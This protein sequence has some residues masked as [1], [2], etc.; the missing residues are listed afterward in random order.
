MGT[1][2]KHTEYVDQPCT[3]CGSK[4][5]IAK[6]WKEK[7]PNYSGGFTEVACT[8]IECSNKECQ[9]KFEATQAE[10]TAKREVNRVKKEANDTLRKANALASAHK[11]RSTNKSRI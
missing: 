3:R 6:T 10:E 9:A 11:T 4:R 2:I 7:I 8:Q 1:N 5:F